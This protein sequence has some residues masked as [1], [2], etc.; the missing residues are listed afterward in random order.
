M[1]IFISVSASIDSTLISCWD[2]V[3]RVSQVVSHVTDA[4]SKGAKAIVG[5]DRNYEQGER[6]YHPS[7]LVGA[8]TDMRFAHEE[9]FGPIAPVIK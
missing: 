9:T 5:G 3:I 6:Y 4:T 7:L 8:N 2:V 1:R